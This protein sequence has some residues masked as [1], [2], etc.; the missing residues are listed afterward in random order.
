MRDAEI[1]GSFLARDEQAIKE[2][3]A[4][5]GAFLRTLAKSI[6]RR[7]EDAE[8]VVNDALLAVWQSIPP[9]EPGSLKAYLGRLTRN[10]AISRYR[11]ENALRRGSGA[12]ALLGELAECI[13]SPINVEESCEAE[14]LTGF[15]NEW[16][17]GLPE[18]DRALFIRRYWYGETVGELAVRS[19]ELPT[20]L[21]KKLY[22]L[23][24]KLKVFLERK[25]VSV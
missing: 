7:P 25:G 3:E 9:N 4:K 13:P 11:K 6:L 22:G 10:G 12:P 17:D 24:K 2:T 1:I 19:G 14:E 21:S 15:I 16:L 5:Y 8:E 23:R 20:K 18:Y